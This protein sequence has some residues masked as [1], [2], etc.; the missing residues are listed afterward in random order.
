MAKTNTPQTPGTPGVADYFNGRTV[1]SRSIL[2]AQA[3][4]ILILARCE[5]AP[6][7]A[8]YFS[9]RLNLPVTEKMIKVI[10]AKAAKGEIIVTREDLEKAAMAH[11]ISAARMHREP[12]L[13]DPQCYRSVF[14]ATQKK[15]TRPGKTEKTGGPKPA[16]KPTGIPTEKPVKRQ[17][18]AA[19]GEP[20]SPPRLVAE[21]CESTFYPNSRGLLIPHAAQVVYIARMARSTRR[22]A[23]FLSKRF[24]RKISRRPVEDILAKVESGEIVVTTEELEAAANQHP[25]A[26]QFA[27]TF[28][29]ALH[30][31]G[32]EDEP[33][34]TVPTT[35]LIPGKIGPAIHR[36]VQILATHHSLRNE[37]LVTSFL[38]SIPAS[39]RSAWKPENHKGCTPVMSAIAFAKVHLRKGG[40]A[41]HAPDKGKDDGI[42]LTPKG[43][44]MA[45]GLKPYEDGFLKEISR[46][47]L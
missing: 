26:Q 41:R 30:P 32:R 3:A 33:N 6:K 31:T 20:A 4:D 29:E 9:A 11:P 45:K 2:I 34:G 8:R 28:P 44:A 43:M 46:G 10:K 7:T 16:A 22:T 23:A 21:F 39:Q 14:P 19:P 18:T 24:G 1:K 25:Y 17:K 38:K 27:K 35:E 36:I 15:T 37:E 13:C 40:Y 5:G 47:E 42:H 12:S